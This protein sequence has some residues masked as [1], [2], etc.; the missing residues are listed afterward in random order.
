MKKP[1]LMIGAVLLTSY[2]ILVLP[3]KGAGFDGL[4]QGMLFYWFI[5]PA[6]LIALVIAVI[7]VLLKRKSSLQQPM[8]ARNNNQ[9]LKLFSLLITIAITAVVCLG[10]SGILGF[11]DNS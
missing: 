5:T 2:L 6:C 9:S 3:F 8:S 10:I 4:F 11:L 1:I 7:S